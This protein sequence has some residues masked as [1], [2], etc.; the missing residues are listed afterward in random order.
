MQVLDSPV[1]RACSSGTTLL[2]CGGPEK[3]VHRLFTALRSGQP[4]QMSAR[5]H[6][7]ADILARTEFL[8]TIGIPHASLLSARVGG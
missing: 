1:L 7:I 2:V 6:R 8:R 3:I 5:T 4:L